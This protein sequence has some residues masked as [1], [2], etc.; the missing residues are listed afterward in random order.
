M[1]ADLRT[2]LDFLELDLL[3]VLLGLVLPFVLFIQE[4]AVVHD[5]TN[6]RVRLGGDLDE[7]E[8]LLPGQRKSIRNGEN[9]DLLF[10]FVDHSYFF[11]VNHFVRPMRFGLPR[12]WIKMVS[13]KNARPP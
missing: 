9:P 12:P 2:E 1:D 3:L 13:S 6:G 8:P 4:L 11:G 10:L 7:I 5:P